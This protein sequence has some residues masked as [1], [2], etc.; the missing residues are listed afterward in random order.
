MKTSLELQQV[1]KRLEDIT[2]SAVPTP[3]QSSMSPP[4]FTAI[5][6]PSPGPRVAPASPPTLQSQ[7]AERSFAQPVE[8]S[9][10]LETGPT[11]ETP[12]DEANMS[13]ESEF[14]FSES[15]NFPDNSPRISLN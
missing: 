7:D 12:V 3:P 4:T 14:D 1:R 13:S 5:P 8:A 11:D 10:I 15:F 6:T 2:T 9:I